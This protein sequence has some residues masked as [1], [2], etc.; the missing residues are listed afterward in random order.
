[1]RRRKDP[2]FNPDEFFAG[3]SKSQLK[4]DMLELQEMGTALDQ[5]PQDRLDAIEMSDSLR[6]AM[7]ELK[8]L[9][10][11]EARRR[12]M[13]YIGKLLRDEDPERFRR[14][15]TEYKQGQN[16]AIQLLQEME[17]WRQRLLA[18][19]KGIVAWAEVYPAADTPAFRKLVERARHEM[20]DDEEH[21]RGGSK[22]PCYRELFQAV[23]DALQAPKGG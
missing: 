14:A 3:P 12:H 19:E 23:R 17:R 2:D 7:A 6:E 21:G 13:Q 9:K 15:L 18:D 1:M 5:L 20:A 11:G 8:R 4:R 16:R 22:G 10:N